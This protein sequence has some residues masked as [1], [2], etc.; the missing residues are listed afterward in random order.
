MIYNR[1]QQRGATLVVSLIMLVMLTLFAV[2]GFNL[3]KSNLQ[4]VG[5]MQQRSQTAAAA[6]STMEEV[7]SGIRFFQSPASV[8]F[9]PCSAGPNTRCVDINGDGSPDVTVTFTPIPVCLTGKPIMNSSL[10]LTKPNDAGCALGVVQ[11]FGV[12]GSATGDSLCADSV[13]QLN[14]VAVDNVT[15]AQTSLTEGVAVRVSSDDII[16]SCP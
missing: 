9:S 1:R 15:Q 14:A 8:F 6:Q 2:T 3:G 16:A 13:W 11:N 10:D 12:I 4:V 7:I 5:N